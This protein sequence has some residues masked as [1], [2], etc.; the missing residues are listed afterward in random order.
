ALT[1]KEWGI[2]DDRIEPAVGVN[3]V[4]GFEN[5]VQWFPE[6]FSRID[7]GGQ[8][9]L[10]NGVEFGAIRRG[11][12]VGIGRAQRIGEVVVAIVKFLAWLASFEKTYGDYAVRHVPELRGDLLSLCEEGMLR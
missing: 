1:T 11:A 2:P 4:W 5:P 10:K 9:G 6:G 8:T 3:D 12:I 7:R